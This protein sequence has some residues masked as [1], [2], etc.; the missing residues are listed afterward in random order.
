[1]LPPSIFDDKPCLMEFSTKG[2]SSMLGT[3]VSREE[4]S[5]SLMTRSLSRPKRTTSMSR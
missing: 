5:S 3:M 4:V 1:M 2:C